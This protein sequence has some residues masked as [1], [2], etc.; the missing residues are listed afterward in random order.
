MAFAISAYFL[1]GFYQ[2]SDSGGRPEKYPSPSRLYSALVSTAYVSFGF[3][4]PDVDYGLTDEQIHAALNW[5]EG[6]PPQDILFPHAIKANSNAI[7]YRNKGNVQNRKKPKDKKSPAAAYIATAYEQRPESGMVLTWVW[8]ESP[9]SEI[10]HTLSLL[11][12]E[13]PYLGEACSIVELHVHEDYVFPADSQDHVRALSTYSALTSISKRGWAFPFPK[14]GR[15]EDLKQAFAAANPV[16]KGKKKVPAVSDKEAEQ[17]F[18]NEYLPLQ[19]EGQARYLSPS[20][21]KE[22]AL[23]APWTMAFYLEIDEVINKGSANQ[24]SNDKIEWK[25]EESEFVGWAVAL[26]RFLVKQ[27]GVDPSLALVGKY[28]PGMNRPANNVSIQIFDSEFKKAYGQ[29]LRKEIAEKGPGFLILLP[30]DMAKTDIQKL[31][32]VCTR[33]KGKTLYY[34]LD[35][36][37]LRFGDTTV[38]DAE[39]LWKPVAEGMC[40]Y[41]TVRP[42]AIAETRPIPDPKGK[43]K[44]GVY[45]ALCLALGHVW[46]DNYVPKTGSGQQ[47]KMSREERYWNLVDAVRAKTSNFRIFSSRAVHRVNMTDY[48]HHADSSNVLH[49]MQALVAIS[50]GADSL[51]CAAMAIGQSRHLGGGFLVPVD[52]CL[53]ALRPDDDFG[54]GVPTWLK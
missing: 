12:N 32:D 35:K 13:V 51:D 21:Q 3:E 26:H 38:I 7:A 14:K 53:S 33:V 39:H 43:R 52:L 48:A 37:T 17:N 42:M 29:Q 6:N 18:L 5:L 30:C 20:A 41:W 22:N 15:L 45:E 9:S 49:G 28:A 19:T 36:P 50:D 11:C 40:R 31:H 10:V 54:K 44:W 47:P 8:H 34:S 24:A 4:K 2:G 23:K 1:L 25:P 46:R 16:P 27:W